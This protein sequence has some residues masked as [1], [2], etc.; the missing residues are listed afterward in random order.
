MTN[1]DFESGFELC[2][3]DPNWT[4]RNDFL[5]ASKSPEA[6][7]NWLQG[8]TSLLYSTISRTIKPTEM[9]DPRGKYSIEAQF[10][11]YLND[12][13]KLMSLLHIWN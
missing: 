9:G 11:T 1:L 2:M 8:E 12:Y 3:N 6:Q 13:Y 4:E 10:K 7:R 5:T